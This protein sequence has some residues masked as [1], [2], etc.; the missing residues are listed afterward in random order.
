[1]SGQRPRHRRGHR[2]SLVGMALSA[3]LFIY[4]TIIPVALPPSILDPLH[5]PVIS[6]WNYPVRSQ[7]GD[8]A[9][10]QDAAVTL[11]GIYQGAPNPCLDSLCPPGMVMVLVSGGQTYFLASSNSTEYGHW[12]WDLRT[13]WPPSGET[14]Q[15]GAT[16]QVTGILEERVDVNGKTFLEVE[17]Q[18]LHILSSPS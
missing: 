11:V 8:R 5:L 18:S 12:T 16:V 2:A 9:S 15:I 10:S 7:G 17:V 6:D 1:M 4:F 14:P 3:I 13:S